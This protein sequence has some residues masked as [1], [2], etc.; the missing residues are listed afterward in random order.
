MNP[1]E[2]VLLGRLKE[3]YRNAKSPHPWYGECD[4]MY[5]GRCAACES[6]RGLTPWF[7]MWLIEG[8]SKPTQSELW[9]E[10]ERQKRVV[11][12]PLDL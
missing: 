11:R 12:S 9:D 6:V 8:L 5:D 7:W 3:L 4:A 10:S 2:N 1:S